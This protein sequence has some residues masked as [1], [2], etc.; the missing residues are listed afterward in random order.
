MYYCVS[1]FCAAPLDPL[2]R[3]P[4]LK[5]LD[6]KVTMRVAGR[7]MTVGLQLSIEDYALQAVMTPN[8]S[9]AYHCREMFRYWLDGEDGCG[10]LP[11]TWSSVLDAVEIGC[12][13]EV[14]RE[15]AETLH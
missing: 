2:H 14:R 9:N 13:S 15:I 3:K 8:G 4:T 11:R 1:I 5:D 7:W 10:A 12:G 6:N